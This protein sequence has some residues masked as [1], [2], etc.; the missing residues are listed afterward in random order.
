M[1]STAQ[2]H[3]PVKRTALNR[4]SQ[5]LGVELLRAYQVCDRPRDL[6]SLVIGSDRRASEMLL[7][8][9]RTAPA[10]PPR[11]GEVAAGAALQHRMAAFR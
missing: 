6:E 3:L 5:M 7:D 9:D 10:A 4:F 1:S 11:L 2:P 8:L